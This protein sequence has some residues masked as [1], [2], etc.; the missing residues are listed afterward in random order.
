M[1]RDKDGK[2]LRSI[3]DQE[4]EEGAEKKAEEA[5]DS[6]K[7]AFDFVKEALGGK[8]KEVKASTRLKSHPVCLTAGEGLSF[9]MEKYFQAVQPD[10]P[11]KA[12]RI[13]ELNVEHPVFQALENAVA[14]DPEKAKKYAQ[15]LYSQA[16]LIAGLPLD[17]P[18]GY[19][20]LVCEL[21]K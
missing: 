20:D 4:I 9:E 17:D 21:M 19:T 2:E 10:S 14:E 11:I 18:S 16:L 15:L 8:V 1:V 5:A 13:L 3:L 6:H 7:A 12:D